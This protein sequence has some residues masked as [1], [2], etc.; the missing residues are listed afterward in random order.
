MKNRKVSTL[1]RKL[2]VATVLMIAAAITL[3]FTLS[4]SSA[5]DRLKAMPGYE[6]FQR[7]SPQIQEIQRSVGSGALSVTWVDG[8]KA[9]T[10]STGSKSYRYDVATMQA[11]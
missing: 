9:F 10:Y 5:Q 6:Q 4:T 11:T 7:I 2:V 1:H 8:G 3:S